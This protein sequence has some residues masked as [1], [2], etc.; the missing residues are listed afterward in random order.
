MRRL[1]GM[2]KETINRTLF[3]FMGE[4]TAGIPDYC[5]DASPRSLLN[6]VIAKIEKKVGQYKYAQSLDRICLADTNWIAY[7]HF[8]GV[9]VATAEQIARACCG[10]I[11]TYI[12]P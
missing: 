3:A 9:T 2:D 12:K 8:S 1:R 7:N 5:S 6:S 11:T 10:V 4:P